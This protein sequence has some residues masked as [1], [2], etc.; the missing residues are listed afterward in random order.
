MNT[1]SKLVRWV[2]VS[3]WF[4]LLFCVIPVFAVLNYTYGLHLPLVGT[5]PLLANNALFGLLIALR[6]LRYLV[7]LSKKQR[8]GALCC[9]PGKVAELPQPKAEVVG[10]LSAAGF[11]FNREQTYGERFDLGYLGTTVF[12]GALMLVLV[13][14]TLDNLRQFSG[15]LM[16]GQGPPTKL[17]KIDSYR[18]VVAGP[19]TG[20]LKGMPQMKVTQQI[21]PNEQ[22]P[23]GATEIALLYPDNTA[24][25]QVL[26]PMERMY[27]KGFELFPVRF[28]FEP[29]ILIRSKDG[30]TLCNGLLTMMPVVR[31][32]EEYGFYAPFK[33]PDLEGNV[34]YKPAVKKFRVVMKHHGAW[35]LDAR[36]VFQEQQ[37]VAQGDYIVSCERLGQ[38]TEI[39]VVRSRHK[40][41]LIGSAV[42]AV[43]G[44]LVRLL[45]PTQRIWIEERAAGCA[46]RTRGKKAAAAL[47]A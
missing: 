36:W 30:K 11:S 16:D 41:L 7:V 45:V 25:K 33:G 43:L 23:N 28:T 6:F 35:V 4:L 21:F 1:D 26:R 3:P 39:K 22:Y 2:L 44:L 12:Y 31:H 10:K 24:K 15:T 19:L 9:R 17:D 18:D 40:G 37:E 29:E 34:Y 32:G 13:V 8:Y 47:A 38:W 20:S 42:F 46:I 27:F 14:G 5:A